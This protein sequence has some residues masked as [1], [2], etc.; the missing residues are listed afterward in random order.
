MFVIDPNPDI[1]KQCLKFDEKVIENAKV[2]VFTPLPVGP[3]GLLSS[4]SCADA[5]LTLLAATPNS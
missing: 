3:E 5:A 1:D 4:P 2:A